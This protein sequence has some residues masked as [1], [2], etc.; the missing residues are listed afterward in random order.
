MID[1]KK[2]STLQKNRRKSGGTTAPRLRWWREENVFNPNATP[3]FGD[4]SRGRT[5]LRQPGSQG[6]TERGD[7]ASE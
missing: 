3:A 4:G 7:D 1:K 5:L 2:L 6:Y